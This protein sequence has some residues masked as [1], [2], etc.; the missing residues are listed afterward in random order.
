MLIQTLPIRKM[1]WL[2]YINYGIKTFYI[3]TYYLIKTITQ[4]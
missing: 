3:K 4:N 1:D 2:P